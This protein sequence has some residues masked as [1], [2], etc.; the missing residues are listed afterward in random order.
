MVRVMI[1]NQPGP[2]IARCG[3]CRTTFTVRDETC[4]CPSCG[5]TRRWV[6]TE[7]DDVASWRLEWV[8]KAEPAA[9]S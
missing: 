9:H 7:Q 8:P 1:E 4:R 3:L 5:A 2:T 6:C